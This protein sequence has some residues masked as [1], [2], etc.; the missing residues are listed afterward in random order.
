M[1][2]SSRFAEH[3]S[4]YRKHASVSGWLFA[5][6]GARVVVADI[7]PALAE[8]TV[9]GIEASGGSALAAITDVRDAEGV[10]RLARTVL[11]RY[12]RADVSG[13]HSRVI[14]FLAS[15]LSAFDGG[16]GAAGGWSRS[17]RRPDQDWTNRPLAP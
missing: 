10:A 5:R 17:S 3:T 14:L 11:D 9:E 7:E 13:Q 6:H 16:T 8:R 12:G 15:D 1:S 2:H 4:G